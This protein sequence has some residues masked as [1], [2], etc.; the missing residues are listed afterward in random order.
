MKKII[1]GFMVVLVVVLFSACG[2]KDDPTVNCD[3]NPEHEDCLTIIDCDETPEHPT[4]NIVYSFEDSYD[5]LDFEN[6][7]VDEFEDLLTI[8]SNFLINN[9]A[10]FSYSDD[11]LFNQFFTANANSG[12]GISRQKIALY[13]QN[14]DILLD[15]IENIHISIPNEVSSFAFNPTDDDYIEGTEVDAVLYEDYT[16][17]SS[18]FVNDDGFK[19]KYEVELTSSPGTIVSLY[20]ISVAVTPD[21]RLVYELSAFSN[22]NEE[23][24]DYL[25]IL[26]DSKVGYVIKDLRY[27][28]E[29]L[30]YFDN[31]VDINSNTSELIEIDLGGYRTFTY[32]LFDIS[33]DLYY[34]KGLTVSQ[35]GKRYVNDK[36][37]FYNGLEEV[38]AIE[39]FLELVD[40]GHLPTSYNLTYNIMYLNDWDIVYEDYLV[41]NNA[42]LAFVSTKDLDSVSTPFMLVNQTLTE[43]PTETELLNPYNGITFDHIDYQDF[44]NEINRIYALDIPVLYEQNMAS[45]KGIDYDIRT[46]L[47]DLF[48]SDLPTLISDRILEQMI[49]SEISFLGEDGLIAIVDCEIDPDNT[50]CPIEE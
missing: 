32:S 21:D 7:E 41:K 13:E 11:Y 4:C 46:D 49:V 1:S 16:G 8:M 37:S 14:D 12:E 34:K 36:V 2:P 40:T 47:L 43:F 30:Y 44:S 23:S 45:V 5:V 29:N 48:T 24:F 35:I 19:Y 28:N 22:V 15:S 10:L 31:K 38:A 39:R 9:A 50:L 33:E 26:Y 3:E 27:Y 42:E 20:D 6:D 18:I 25:Y 17:T